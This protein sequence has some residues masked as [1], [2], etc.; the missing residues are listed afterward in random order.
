MIIVAVLGLL[1]ALMIATTNL[2]ADTNLA[3]QMM[4]RIR[5]QDRSYY[6]AQSAVQATVPLL[7][8]DGGPVTLQDPWAI[9]VQPFRLDGYLIAVTISDEERFINPNAMLDTDGITTNPDQVR[10]FKRLLTL[11][12]VQNVEEITNAMLDWMDSDSNRRL[13][14]GAEGS[15]YGD[16]VPKNAPFDSLDEILYVKGVPHDLL[17]GP[18]PGPSP[19]PTPPRAP[20]T[21]GVIVSGDNGSTTPQSAYITGVGSQSTG[22]QV[23]H[24]LREFISI[25][26]TGTVNVNTAPPMVLESLDSNFDDGLVSAIIQQRER[27][28]FQTLDDMLNVPGITR[29]DLYYLH[30]VADVKSTTWQ[31]RVDVSPDAGPSAPHTPPLLTLRAIYRGQGKGIP[32][33]AWNLEQIGSGG[34]SSQAVPSGSPTGSPSPSPSDQPDGL[35]ASTPQPSFGASPFNGATPPSINH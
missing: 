12:G 22:G 10:V 5:E 6:V 7:P 1:A 16:H 21:T 32:P 8:T 31:I 34:A 11:L 20:P 14:G 28:P 13:P 9:G 15:D 4:Q 26:A 23:Q 17:S 30:K 18:R 25:Y 2:A 35:S 29:D 3:V 19:S 27:Q 24:G 33:L